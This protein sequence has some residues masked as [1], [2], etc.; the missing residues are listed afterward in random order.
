[1]IVRV[2]SSNHRIDG[3]QTCG[4]MVG[5]HP[6]APPRV[7]AEHHVG[8]DEANDPGEVPATFHR[9]G[10]FAVDRVEKVSGGLRVETL[11][12]SDLLGLSALNQ[13]V[14][15]DVGIPAAFGTIGADQQ[16]NVRSGLTPFG[17]GGT[18]P[19][20]NI[21]G[22]S[23]DSQHTFGSREVYAHSDDVQSSEF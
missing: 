15:V 12:C 17:E 6:P 4:P 7:M 9:V 2:T 5:V 10:Q 14:A 18:A 3:E 11:C 16:M 8:F 1:V 22:V 21:V 20:F 19:E 13:F 23:T